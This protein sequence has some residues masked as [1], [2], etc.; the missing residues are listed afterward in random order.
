MIRVNRRLMRQTPGVIFSKGRKRNVVIEINPGGD[1]KPGPDFLGFRLMGTRTT[2]Y[3]PVD[4]CFRE[5]VK[6][7]MARRRREKREQRKERT[8]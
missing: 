5:A 1:G 4:W 2:Y 8:S 3:L 7:E 6:A